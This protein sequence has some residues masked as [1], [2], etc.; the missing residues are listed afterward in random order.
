M[1]FRLGQLRVW[2]GAKAALGALMLLGAEPAAAQVP[3]PWAHDLARGLADAEQMV[4]ERHYSRVAGPFAGGLPARLTRRVQL[5]MRAGQQY[6]IIGVC[7]ARCGDLNL[8][9][10][11]ANDRLIT[12]DVLTNNV[13]ILDVSPPLTGLYTIEVEMARCAG[14][15]CYYAF[16]VYARWSG[17]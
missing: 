11:D 2:K 15:P 17:K 4:G 6:E 8:R 9:M 3:D 13:P 10:Y 7:D 5:T 14:D 1:A 16:N 12:E